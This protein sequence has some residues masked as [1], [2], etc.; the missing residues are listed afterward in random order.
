M[1]RFAR[2]DNFLDGASDE[3]WAENRSELFCV[4]KERNFAAVTGRSVLCPYGEGMALRWA[5]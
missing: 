4:A 5:A 2:D 3:R 1:P